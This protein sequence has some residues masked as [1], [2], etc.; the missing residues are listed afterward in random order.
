MHI[1]I[2]NCPDP[3]F[4]K[5][6][7]NSLNFYGK[8]LISSTRILNNIKVKIKFDNKLEVYAL[9]S[10]EG[11]NASGKPRQFKIEIH[12]WIGAREILATLAHEMVHVKQYVYGEINDQLSCWRGA[13]V[14]SDTLDYYEHPW[15]LDAY[16][17]E[18]GLFTKYAIHDKLWEIFEGISNPTAP[19]EFA[20]IKWKNKP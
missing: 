11:C 14:D 20:E 4:N 5:Y 15:E 17:R 9:S 3:N 10:I 8:Q 12:P 19:I 1:R 13:K 6:I 16:S 7:I 18:V 2:V